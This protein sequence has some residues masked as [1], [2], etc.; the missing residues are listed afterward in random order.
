MRF[1]FTGKIAKE[2]KYLTTSDDIRL[3]K[4]GNG[5][6]SLVGF[7]H[8][9]DGQD[10]KRIKFEQQGDH[11]GVKDGDIVNAALI[12]TPQFFGIDQ[13]DNL[14][15]ARKALNEGVPLNSKWGLPADQFGKHVR[16]TF[17][18]LDNESYGECEIYDL[19]IKEFSW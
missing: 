2:G 5:K 15:E 4:G 14:D 7:A 6:W 13:W 19:K 18:F 3:D 17:D 12:D 9:P 8:N 11:Y 1:I 16:I 10:V